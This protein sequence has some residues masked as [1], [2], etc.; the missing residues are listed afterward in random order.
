MG[1]VCLSDVVM[2]PCLY[3]HC[4]RMA[5]LVPCASCAVIIDAVPTATCMP[6]CASASTTLLLVLYMQPGLLSGL[7]IINV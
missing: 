5:Q 6:A 2:Y 1:S 7:A 4:Q 3:T